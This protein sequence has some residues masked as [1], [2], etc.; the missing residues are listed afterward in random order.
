MANEQDNSGSLTTAL[1]EESSSSSETDTDAHKSKRRK[2]SASNR[3]GSG[4]SV[5]A[6]AGAGGKDVVMSAQTVVVGK[7]G[8]QRKPGN[9][10]NELHVFPLGRA[11]NSDTPRTKVSFIQNDGGPCT[12]EQCGQTFQKQHQL[13]LHMNIHYMNPGG[14]YRC[15]PC[16]TTFNTRG[17]LQKHLRSEVHNSSSKNPRPFECTYCNRAFR[18]QGHLA[19]H[20]RSKTHVQRLECLQKL[21][22]GTYNLI[23][24]ARI[25][26]SDIDT[27]DC[28]SSLVSLKTLAEQL[29][30][31]ADASDKRRS[32]FAGDGH[33]SSN[34]A[35][36]GPVLHH[37]R[38]ILL[39]DNDTD[40]AMDA[41]DMIVPKKRKIS[42]D[43]WFRGESELH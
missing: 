34:D 36:S 42:E 16:G 25:R 30:P 3:C 2:F 10:S 21:P 40:D 35:T 38:M 33:H 4:T 43:L 32:P 8:F 20:L 23:E 15:E 31:D 12:C 13:T 6:A 5:A 17:L 24:E 41:S 9:N 29:K 26:L 19:K 28:D 39:S 7:D 14:K 22:F 1:L 27:T 18:I 11:G 37:E